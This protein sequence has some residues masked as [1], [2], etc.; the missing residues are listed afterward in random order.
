MNGP[1]PDATGSA[2][3]SPLEGFTV[4]SLVSYL[5]FPARTPR[6]AKKAVPFRTR[7]LTVERLEDRALPAFTITPTFDSTIT[8]DANA[9]AIENTINSAISFYES[10]F[11]NSIDVTIKFK[12]MSSGAGVS[13]VTFYPIPYNTFRAALAA[14]PQTAD[15]AI[16]L[17]NLPNQTNNPVNNDANLLIKTA[18][19]RA[20]DI[21]GSFPPMGGFDGVVSLNT[22]ISTPGSPGSTNLFSLFALTEHEIDEVLGLGSALPSLGSSSGFPPSDPLPEDLYRYTASGNRTWI[23]TGD[24]AYFSLDG[25]T[26]LVQFNQGNVNNNDGDYGDWWSNNGL[27]NAGLNPPARVQDATNF[28]ATTPTLAN[29]AGHVEQVALNVIGYTLGISLSPGSLPADTINVAYNQ[30]I[31]ASGGTGSTTLTVTNIQNPIV[32]LN[33]PANGADSLAI[34]GTPTATGTETFTVTATDQNGVTTDANYSMTVNAAVSL[35]PT[36]LPAGASG[37]AYDATIAATG[38]TGT[39]TPAVTNYD[40]GG[41]GLSAPAISGN[42]ASFNSTPTAAG[43]VSF[44]VTATDAVGAQATQHYTIT[45]H[46]PPSITTTTLASYWTAGAAGYNQTIDATGGT[47]TLTFSVSAGALP[48]GL[49]LD[50]ASGVLA[51]TPAPAGSFTFTVTVTDTV[52]ASASQ[53]YT[54]VVIPSEFAYDP[55]LQQLTVTPDASFPNFQFQQATTA[56]AGGTS[57]LYTLTLSDNASPP[58]TVS[59]MFPDTL[60]P[61]P[62]SFHQP[63]ILVN[64][65]GGQAVLITNDTY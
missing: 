33:V 45:V 61:I 63:S 29:D 62:I 58:N 50:S 4:R 43:T 38:G 49:T 11:T 25:T 53:S 16:A 30:S 37:T 1:S 6:H 24:D 56:N 65:S 34:T 36:S 12:E 64:G 22:S 20:L 35:S 52:A 46:A 28:A 32:G 2:T 48:T 27:G 51:G 42:T 15:T 17:A 26:D 60:L 21:P 7:R 9:A 40:D 8:G 3:E 23:N 44:D 59:Q 55:N 19:I 31:T 13:D 57:T 18:D 5:P 47:G 39:L 41:T 10:A 14:E 54:I